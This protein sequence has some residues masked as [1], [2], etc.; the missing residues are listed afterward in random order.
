M[1]DLFTGADGGVAFAKLHHYF[2]PEILSQRGNSPEV[3]EFIKMIYQM[4]HLCELM[5][6]R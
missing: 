1:I 5:K 3:D 2:L 6:E 4:S